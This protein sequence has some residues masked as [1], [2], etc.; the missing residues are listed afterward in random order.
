[1]LVSW[2]VSSPLGVQR[3]QHK[4]VMF[5]CRLLF[6]HPYFLKVWKFWII[7]LEKEIRMISTYAELHSDFFLSPHCMQASFS[8]ILNFT[9][10]NI[11]K[12][13]MILTY[14]ELHSDFF[15]S[16][17]FMQD[18]FLTS[19]GD[20]SSPILSFKEVW[21]RKTCVWCQIFLFDN[22]CQSK[23]TFLW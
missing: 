12:T 18:L 16:P 17:R 13:K 6:W 8:T 20:S 11:L 5:I 23:L 15:L 4:N 19:T 1:M 10:T 14:A 9:K 22:W 2:N 3:R 7:V 21:R